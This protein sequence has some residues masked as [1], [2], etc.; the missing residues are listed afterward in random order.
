MVWALILAMAGVVGSAALS[1]QVAAAAVVPPAV[2]DV[3]PNSVT[4]GQLYGGRVE[5]LSV[6]PVNANKM[7]AGTEL[8]GLW[9]T[10][11]GAASWQHVDAVPLITVQ[12]VQVA[13]SDSSL[14]VAVG[15]Y[16]GSTVSQGGIWRSNDGGITWAKSAGSDPPASCPESHALSVS[17]GTGTPGSLPVYV[18]DLCGLTRSNLSAADNS[19]TR[20]DP[21]GS[22]DNGIAG[23]NH[24]IEDVEVRPS[25]TNP[26]QLQVDVCGPQGFF[27]SDTSGS[28][29]SAADPN[30]P[31]FIDD[32]ADAGPAGNRA[33]GVCN[34][35]IA[36][37]N[38]NIVYLSNFAY[39]TTS[40]F[41][42]GRLEENR[43]G[44]A[45][46]SW[47]SM[48]DDVGNENCRDTF[49]Q[50]QDNND[51][52]ST[53][54]DVYFGGSVAVYRQT[55]DSD[56]SPSCA[57]GAGSWP[58]FDAGTPH[59]DPANIAFNAAS[60]TGCPRF[61]AGDGGVI[62]IS[63]DGCAMGPSMSMANVGLHALDSSQMTGTVWA[64]HLD[65]YFGTQDNGTFYTSDG[66]ANY[67]QGG[68]DTYNLI[69][70]LQGNPGA[71]VL[72][73][74]C[75]GCGVFRQA[76]GAIG[77][78]N[79]PF[80][81]PPA[82]WNAD[83]GSTFTATQFGPLSYAIIARDSAPGGANPPPNWAVWVT[84]NAGGN[85]TQFG[86]NLPAGPTP[87]AGPG[88]GSH[89]AIQAAGPAD[90]PTFY[91]NA[92]A[93]LYRLSGVLDTSVAS[94][95]A[96]RTDLSNGGTQTTTQV[97]P[98]AFFAVDSSNPNLLYAV[99]N[100]AGSF[101]YRSTNGG[102]SWARDT[103]ATALATGNGSYKFFANNSGFQVT[104]LGFDPYSD[105]L[106]LGTRS[107]GL[108]ASLNNGANWVSVAGSKQVTIALDFLFDN[109]RNDIY[110]GTRGRG[111]WR[112]DLPTADMKLSKLDSPDPVLAGN[113]LTYYVTASN[114]GPDAGTGLAVVDTLPD[115]TDFVA[116]TIET[117]TGSTDAGCVVD[118]SSGDEVVTCPLPDVESGE[119]VTLKL[120]TQVLPNA[121]SANGGP[122]TI[123]NTATLTSSLVAD[124]DPSNNSATAATLVNDSADLALAKICDPPEAE[125]GETIHCTVYVDNHGPSDARGVV[126]SDTVTS[127]GSF[128]IS[129]I[130]GGPGAVCSPVT[131]VPGGKHFEC[132]VG[133]IK[134]ATTSE[135]G[136][137]TLT[138]DISATEGQQLD[139][140][141]RARS[142]TPDPDDTNNE[143]QESL[144]ITAVADVSVTKSG[145]PS[146]VAG[147]SFDYT[148]TA[149]N[150]GPSTA[151][152]VVVVDTLPAGVVIN[153][154]SA[155]GATCQ[156]GVPGDA[157]QPTT[158][159]FGSLAPGASTSTMTINVTVKPETTGVL[160]NDARVSS[161]TFDKDTSNNLA[162]TDTTVTTSADLAVT[163][164]D[165]PDPVVAGRPITYTI[166]VRNSSGPSLARDVA[167][168]DTLPG[169][170]DFTGATIQHGSG[171]CAW[172]S[173]PPN[174]VVCQLGNLAPADYVVV[175]VNGTVR[176]AAP[177]GISLVNTVVVTSTTAD[178]ND[179]DN[180]AS[181]TTGVTTSADL[182]VTHTSDVDVY[183]PS[184]TI[185]Y[186]ITVQNAGPSDAVNVVITDELPPS[187]S[188]SYVSDDGG[189]TLSGT[190]LT[191]PGFTLAAGSTRNLQVKFFVQGSKGT[192]QATAT[193]TS[194]TPDPNTANNSATRTVTRK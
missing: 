84:T 133:T 116:G 98:V 32:P 137:K 182:A 37:G 110:V 38:P 170:V 175:I 2:T 157:S 12:D 119:Y 96:T 7:F 140:H 115:Q 104:G 100:V 72:R 139:N 69:A 183:K 129:N 63:G 31:L 25:V 65:L 127:S 124:P 21:D 85:W 165:S 43:N 187:K 150:G 154:V 179:G 46:G 87:G 34:I 105:T 185:F 51:L 121:V 178:P 54:Y 191:C 27:R 56:N 90:A 99:P 141:A 36:P 153:S 45:A 135:S 181:T 57:V 164:S 173:G 97:G 76:P 151:Q 145:P 33:F 35:D 184:S 123:V 111:V 15:N 11:D 30:S 130:N 107:N 125:A 5:A 176:S 39:G 20:V 19:W 148:L 189:C 158:C 83:F 29:W 95:P 17:I 52:D 68:P 193:V 113:Q 186:L 152:N 53:T 92:G 143:A 155:A 132:N 22:F 77:G 62:K 4:S 118:T 180:S 61:I 108:Y 136:R 167:L 120:V 9:V 160:H 48:G 1:Q 74:D 24:Q 147:T 88:P 174:K 70:D 28:T 194:A 112:V 168:T 163:K 6:D 41:C 79:I 13:A 91:V 49:V 109:V 122:V 71:S 190:T 67:Q 40:G 42:H 44:G 23:Y 93:R 81:P 131:S 162:S 117:T 64:D 134:A 86:S 58:Q 146:A 60:P 128:T 172:V 188:G 8:G 47:V 177:S 59:T 55:C 10:T 114:D 166:T 18:G 149:S 101:L 144:T 171:S 26:G 106:M 50:V 159:A 80:N 14:V 66:G 16:E 73:R 103:A 82:P 126:I 3:N 75:F 156:A 192:I 138:Y 89:G 142:D 161:G 102:S 169:F 94:N 78:P